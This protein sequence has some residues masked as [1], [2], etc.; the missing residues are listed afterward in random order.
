MSQQFRRLLDFISVTNKGRF[1]LLGGRKG[2]RMK[3]RKKRRRK[4]K[5]EVYIYYRV[6]E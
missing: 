2:V 1:K 5:K 6:S 3:K 4:G